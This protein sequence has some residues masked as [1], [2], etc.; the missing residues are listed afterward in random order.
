MPLP[1]SRAVVRGATR[2]ALRCFRA[3]LAVQMYGLWATSGFFHKLYYWT[4]DTEMLI[5]LE[6]AMVQRQLKGGLSR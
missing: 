6:E 1:R 2:K 3:V 5:A 4:L